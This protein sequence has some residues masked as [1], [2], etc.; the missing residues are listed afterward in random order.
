M[1][2]A[3]YDL[4]CEDPNGKSKFQCV[5]PS[6]ESKATWVVLELP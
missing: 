5:Y 3:A 1:P 6:D 4:A 2:Q